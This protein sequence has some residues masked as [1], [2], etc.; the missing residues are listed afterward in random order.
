[1][2]MKKMRPLSRVG[3]TQTGALVQAALA[4][5]AAAW[6]T[7]CSTTQAPNGELTPASFKGD[8]SKMPADARAKMMEGQAH[9]K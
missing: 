9:P 8:L 1:M 7:G 2:A 5:V 3:A 6:L 4:L